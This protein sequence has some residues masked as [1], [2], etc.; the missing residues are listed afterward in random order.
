MMRTLRRD[1]AYMSILA[2]FDRG[3]KEKRWYIG[4]GSGVRILVLVFTW[5]LG[6][7]T[8]IVGRWGV[9]FPWMGHGVLIRDLPQWT[10]FSDPLVPVFL[11]L[12]MCMERS[13]EHVFL[14]FGT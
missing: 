13:S 10:Y 12:I 2:R 1:D 6:F 7:E 14:S 11:F 9:L 5:V 3:R 8:M 4:L